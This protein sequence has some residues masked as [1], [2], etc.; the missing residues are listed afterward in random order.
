MKI[1]P[2]P[3]R[4][5]NSKP[6]PQFVRILQ[7][8]LGK[9]WNGRK[10]KNSVGF[11][12]FICNTICTIHGAVALQRLIA[13]RLGDDQTFR[14]W[15]AQSGQFTTKQIQEGRRA[16]MLDLIAEFS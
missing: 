10:G 1:V 13:A 15:A 2:I 14:S 7:A 9:L 16:W 4:D 6:N 8:G 11:N 12:Q 3:A 5:P